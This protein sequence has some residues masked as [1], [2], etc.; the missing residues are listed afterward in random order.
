MDGIQGA[1]LSVKLKYIE[2]WNQLRRQH[3]A[4]YNTL[5]ADT[6]NVTVP[7]VIEHNKHVY[8]IY[9]VRTANRDQQISALAEKNIFCG[10]HYPV[11]LHLQKAYKAL[12]LKE[13]D[14]PVAE[15]CCAEYLSLPMFP[16]LRAE[17]IQFV[18]AELRKPESATVELKVA[19]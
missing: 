16:E 8:H 12:N 17:E 10:I 14:F 1:V 7:K 5:L 6:D 4:L 9:A 18:C 13:G 3:A 2:R 11:P 15:R 19:V